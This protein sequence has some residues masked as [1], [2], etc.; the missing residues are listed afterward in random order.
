[1]QSVEP[2]FECQRFLIVLYEMKFLDQQ[3]IFLALE[4]NSLSLSFL[5]KRWY[6]EKNETTFCK[7]ITN[8]FGNDQDNDNW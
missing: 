2:Q 7:T 5:K 6:E 3:Q 8:P 4:W 1:M